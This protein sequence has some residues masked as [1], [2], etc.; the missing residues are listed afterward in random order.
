MNEAPLLS[1]FV[2]YGVPLLLVLIGVIVLFGSCDEPQK[3]D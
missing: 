1:L 2:E 3:I